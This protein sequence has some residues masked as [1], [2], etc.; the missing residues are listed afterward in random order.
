MAVKQ[1]TAMRTVL[2]AVVLCLICSIIVSVA[3]TALKP[4]QTENQIIDR[5]ANILRVVGLLEEGADVKQT[6]EE[7]VEPRVVNLETGEYRE[8]LDPLL[9]DQRLAAQDPNQSQILS[10]PDDIAS[11][12][13]Q[14]KN[15]TVYLI[16][17]EQDE[18]DYVVLPVHG[19]GLWSTLYGFLALKSDLNTVHGIS[20]Y[21]HAETPGLGGEVDNPRWKSLWDGKKVYK[22]EEVALQVVKGNVTD[23]T[24]DAEYKVD[25][26]AGATLTSNG[27][28]NL[29][30]FWLGQN[31]FET[32]LDRLSS[33]QSESNNVAAK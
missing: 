27:V 15:A 33:T 24:P 26:L 9:Y 28:S 7:K 18:I 4:V 32:Y 8:D 19:Y 17:N 6:F 10:A 30:R 21:E 2:V 5:Q 20:F 11:I 31:G 29:V 3:A 12:R 22:G 14:A 13:R 1:D 16:R 23:A 25:G